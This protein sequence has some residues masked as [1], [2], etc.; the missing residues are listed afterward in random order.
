[1]EAD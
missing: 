1:L